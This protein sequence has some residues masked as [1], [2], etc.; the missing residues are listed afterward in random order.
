MNRLDE[1]TNPQPLG[2]YIHAV[3]E[4]FRANHPWVGGDLVRPK[5]VAREMVEVYLSFTEYVRRY[6][7]QRSEGVLLRYLSQVYKTLDQN[8]PDQAKTDDVRDV[9]SFLRAMIERVDTSLIEEWE[10][11]RHPELILQ[12]VADTQST[13]RVLAAQEMRSDPGALAALVRAE[14][15]Q[16]T[17]ALARRDWEEAA[18]CV[19]HPPDAPG[20]LVAPEDF[21]AALEPFFATHESL[22]YDHRARLAERTHLTRDGEHRWRAVQVLLDP[23]DENLWCIEGEVDL[24]DGAW[25]EGPLV[26]VTRIGM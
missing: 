11:L 23:E 15:H 10:S 20:A 3:F 22:I 21:S 5:S 6:G 14:L 7:L 25:V 2:E 18:A 16:L 1:V 4:R 9:V 13:H 12:G 17:A 8:V 19:R 24:A 26:A